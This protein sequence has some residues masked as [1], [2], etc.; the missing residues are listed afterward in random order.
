MSTEFDRLIAAAAEEARLVSPRA[1]PGS[2]I[3]GGASF[4][5]FWP[6]ARPILVTLQ[7]MLPKLAL[8]IALLIAVGDKA[9]P[10]P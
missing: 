1:L 4:C 5:A 8:V 7:D 2:S 6:T 9:C 10:K 3:A